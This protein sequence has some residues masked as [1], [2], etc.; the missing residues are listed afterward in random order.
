MKTSKERTEGVKNAYEK[1]K[2]ARNRGITIA[3]VTAGCALITAGNFLLFTPFSNAHDITVYAGSEYYAV[4]TKLDTI[5]YSPPRYKNNYEKYLKAPISNFFG[6][7]IGCGMAKDDYAGG[8]LPEANWKEDYLETTDNQVQGVIEGDLIKRTSDRIFYLGEGENGYELRA[9]SLAGEV[10]C[11]YTVTPE[12]G[13]VFL[14]NAEM[15]LSED[16]E[17]ITLLTSCATVDYTERYTALVGLSVAQT[18]AVTET[19]RA[20]ASARGSALGSG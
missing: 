5:T 14:D 3:L 6:G 10:L 12:D 9:Y 4:I 8:A 20:W 2:K 19:G 11:R 1:K 13:F 16:G 15:Y 17:T 7:L 18:D